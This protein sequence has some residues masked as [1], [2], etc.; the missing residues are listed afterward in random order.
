MLKGTTVYFIGSLKGYIC[1]R[2]T[3][4][5]WFNTIMLFVF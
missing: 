2:I 4:A 1:K 5:K 3:K